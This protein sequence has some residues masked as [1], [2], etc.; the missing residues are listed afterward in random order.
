[1][2]KSLRKVLR[3]RNENIRKAL[4][5]KIALWHAAYM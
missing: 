2:S 1:M 3:I 5:L 4:E